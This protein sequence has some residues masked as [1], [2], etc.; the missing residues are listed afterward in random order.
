MARNRIRGQELKVLAITDGALE[1]EFQEITDFSIEP[2][3]EGK[4]QGFLGERGNRK[5]DIFNGFKFSFGMQI[6]SSRVFLFINS[7]I[8]RQKRLVPT[9]VFN[10]SGIFTMPDGQGSVAATLPDVKWTSMPITVGSRGDYVTIKLSG[11]C[12]D[13]I[14]SVQ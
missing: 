13:W 12:D 14:V 5:D 6:H 2:E 9:R 7:V 4:S 11:E 1:E 8:E 3:M 10:I